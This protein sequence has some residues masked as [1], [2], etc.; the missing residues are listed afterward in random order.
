[1]LFQLQLKKAKIKAKNLYRNGKLMNHFN[2]FLV[3][4]ILKISNQN[5]IDKSMY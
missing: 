2:K 5:L 3:G 1:M 4:I